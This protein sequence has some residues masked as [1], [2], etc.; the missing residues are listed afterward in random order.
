MIVLMTA[1]LALEPIELASHEGAHLQRPVFAPDGSRIAYEVNRQE[2]GIVETWVGKE[3]AFAPIAPRSAG[4]GLTAGFTTQAA[5]SA[6][7]D[8]T[9]SP[10]GTYVFSSTGSQRDYDL[11]LEG[12]TP[13]AGGPGAEGGPAFSPDGRYLAFTSARTGDGDLYLLETADLAS[14]PRQLTRDPSTAE[15]YVTWHPG[16]KGLAWVA[17]AAD[18]DHIYWAPAMGDEPLQVT[19]GAGSQTRP[20]FSPDGAWI[21]YYQSRSDGGLDL[22]VAQPGSKPFTVAERVVADLRGP[23]WLDGSHLVFVQDLDEAFD[24]IRTVSIH[25]P[26]AA[27][28]LDLPTVGHTDLDVS[29]S[30]GKTRLAY[31]AQGREGESTRSWRRLYM[32]VLE[33]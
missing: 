15:L 22:M 28:T 25:A 2:R 12:G 9:W 11:Y 10:T 27:T 19:R 3:G 4:S 29:W 33:E 8:L 32:V 30:N 5:A 7:H 23:T 18:G 20:T 21:A 31:V 24:P 13:I 6:T 14:P 26:E 1:A 17:H 16:G